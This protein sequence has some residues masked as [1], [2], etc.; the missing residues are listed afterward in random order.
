MKTGIFIT[1]RLGST[2]LARKHLLPVG[3]RPILSYLAGR[4]ARG[5]RSELKADRAKLLIVTSDEPENRRF[6]EFAPLGLEVFYGSV[7]NIPL[8]HLQAA[9]THGLDA[10]VSVD[11]DDIL[12]SVKGMRLVYDTL[13]AGKELVRTS[14][15]PFG[16]NS[17]GYSRAFLAKS[18]RDHREGTLET[19][20]GRIFEGGDMT[21]I[22]VPFHF[23]NELLRFTLDY[24]EDYLFFKTLIE[25]LG[26]TVDAAGDEDIVSTVMGKR[27]YE[28]NEPISREYWSNFYKAREEEIRRS[29]DSPTGPGRKESV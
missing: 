27:L 6:E 20:W 5:F 13:M 7:H 18:L 15:L 29:Q 21:D 1:A 2:R 16:M 24:E 8:R 12:C 23:Q 17:M 11:G 9:E 4:I 22:A 3:G 25:T 28:L 19:G 10:V 26:S 14:N